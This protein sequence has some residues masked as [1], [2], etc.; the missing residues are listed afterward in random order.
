MMHVPAISFEQMSQ[1]N[2]F[3]FPSKGPTKM[4]IQQEPHLNLVPLEAQ[5]FKIW[6]K[7]LFKR[8]LGG[9][10][11]FFRRGSFGTIPASK[12]RSIERF[13]WLG[14]LA[15][16]LIHSPPH[17]ALLCFCWRFR[18]HL[19]SMLLCDALLRFAKSSPNILAQI[20]WKKL[21]VHPHFN[22]LCEAT[23]L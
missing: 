19:L 6:T 22:N 15:R 17:F 8:H 3:F 1:M 16:W 18:L 13:T 5:L 10:P 21:Y 2:R 11:L 7:N 4:W 9:F 12:R 23:Q 20:K 14:T